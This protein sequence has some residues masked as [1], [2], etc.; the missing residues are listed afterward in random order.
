MIDWGLVSKVAT[1]VAGDSRGAPFAGYDI[2]G[3][4]QDAERRIARYTR[5]EPLSNLP[6]PELISRPGWIAA[7]VDSMRPFFDILEARID[8]A[9]ADGPVARA[10]RAATGAVLSTHLGGLT[11]FL[12]QRVLGQYEIPLLDPKGRARLLLVGPNLARAAEKLGARNADLLR[13]VTLHEVTH[14]IQFTGVPW[15]RDHL[16]AVLSELLDSLE[17]HIS[18]SQA[19]R[20]PSA[21]ELRDVVQSARTGGLM[22]FVVGE[23]RRALLDRLQTTM[24]VIEGHAE[25][26]MDAVGAQVIP[27]APALRE[28]LELRRATRSTPLRLIE[29]ILGFELKLRQY[30]E[31]KHFCDALVRSG[32]PALLARVWSAPETLPSTAELANPDLWIERT[33]TPALSS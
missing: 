30:R 17:V 23:E 3:L 32:G 5:L 15:L 6:R 33:A 22:T 20:M 10:G 11:G 2:P 18:A 4:A 26:V 21:D 25:H 12:A 27:A 28:A 24:A 1:M 16:A 8:A 14:G 29:R 19:L 13:W 7:N 9:A 31:G